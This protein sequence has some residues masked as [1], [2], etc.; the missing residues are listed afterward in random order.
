MLDGHVLQPG[1]GQPVDR[2]LDAAVLAVGLGAGGGPVFQSTTSQRGPSRASSAAEHR[3]DPA[4]EHDPRDRGLDGAPRPP[5]ASGRPTRWPGSAACSAA[6]SS[7]AARV[8]G[9]ARQLVDVDQRRR[10]ERCSSQAWNALPRRA[11][12]LRRLGHRPA[13]PV[14]ERV[15]VGRQ[16]DHLRRGQVRAAAR[17]AAAPAPRRPARRAAGPTSRV[18]AATAGRAPGR[19]QLAG[20]VAAVAGRSCRAVSPRQARDGAGLPASPR[21]ARRRAG[22][23]ASSTGGQSVARVGGAV[24]GRASSP[25]CTPHASDPG[26]PPSGQLGDLG[27]EAG[28]RPRRRCRRPRPRP[29]SSSTAPR[30]GHRDVGQP[31]LLGDLV[32]AAR[33]RRNSSK[34]AGEVRLRCGPTSTSQCGSPAASPRSG[35][36]SAPSVAAASRW[37]PD[38]RAAVRRPGTCPRPGRSRRRRPTPGPWRR[39]R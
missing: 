33:E 17:P 12:G 24:L 19:R 28:R 36:G 35:Y 10:P 7:S 4:P 21:R 22:R 26:P 8:V 16:R 23:A 6:R 18:P 38:R 30:P 20:R 31:A 37:T 14:G 15:R 32:L 5:P 29:V 25:T 34:R 39:A 9:G 1:P 11:C 3:V 27:E 2:E 13:Q